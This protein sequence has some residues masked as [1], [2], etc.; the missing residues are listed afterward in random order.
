VEHDGEHWRKNIALRDYLRTSESAREA[1]GAAK[2]AAI[3]QGANS[4]LSYSAAKAD[5]IARI[6]MRAGAPSNAV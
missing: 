4:L 6:L 1:Y 2:R 5:V 3:E